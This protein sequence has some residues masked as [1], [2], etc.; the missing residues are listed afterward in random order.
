MVS[1]KKKK[2]RNKNKK[3][4]SQSRLCWGMDLANFEYFVNN[5]KDTFLINSPAII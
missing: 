4:L 1:K 5:F 2:K 3:I